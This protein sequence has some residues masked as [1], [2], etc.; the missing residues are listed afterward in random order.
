MIVK[1]MIAARRVGEKL[2]M[3]TV[4]KYWNLFVLI[5]LIRRGPE[6]AGS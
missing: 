3:I 5:T 4:W 2:V 1:S 6:S